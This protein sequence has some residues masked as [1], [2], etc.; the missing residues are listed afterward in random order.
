M[1]IARRAGIREIKPSIISR[2]RRLYY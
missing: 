1:G 2:I